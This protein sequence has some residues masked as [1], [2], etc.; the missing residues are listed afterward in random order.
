MDVCIQCRCRV[1]DD[2]R[3]YTVAG[4]DRDWNV[5]SSRVGSNLQQEAESTHA[6]HHQ[7]A[8][9]GVR[10]DATL[11]VLQRRVPIVAVTG[12]NPLVDSARANNSQMDGSSSIMSTIG[13]D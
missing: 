2:R 11:K 9:D 4:H 8:Q 3:H 5:T 1:L 12:K 6:R 10:V 7:V 13:P